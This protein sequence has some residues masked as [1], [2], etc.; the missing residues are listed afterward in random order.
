MGKTVRRINR[1]DQPRNEPYEKRGKDG[2]QFLK[3]ITSVDD[4]DDFYYDD[5]NDDNDS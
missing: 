2:F 4:L 5:E 1:S 3:S